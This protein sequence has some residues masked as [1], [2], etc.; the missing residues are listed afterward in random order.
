MTKVFNEKGTDEGATYAVADAISH[1]DQHP[2]LILMHA[3]K[4]AAHD[5]Q[6]LMEHEV[7]DGEGDAFVGER[8]H[9]KLLDSAGEFQV[10]P[11]LFGDEG[12]FSAQGLFQVFLLGD[13]DAHGDVAVGIAIRI[14]EG[15]YGGIDPVVGAIFTAVFDFA[16]P[17]FAGFDGVPQVFEGTFRHVRVADDIVGL[18]KEFIQGVLGDFAEFLIGI[19]DDAPGVSF[20]HDSKSVYEVGA[21]AQ[22]ALQGFH[23]LLE[24]SIGSLVLG[25]VLGELLNQFDEVGGEDTHRVIFFDLK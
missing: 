8:R 25:E 1:K 23:A 6:G 12:A 2:A 4:V 9:E 24:R 3:D 15:A 19:G 17:D 16:L 14:Q 11:E 13:V 20:T 21:V 5:L 22:L 10:C 18:A 7:G